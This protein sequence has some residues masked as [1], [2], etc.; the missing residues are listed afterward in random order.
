MRAR[1]R[2]DSR[3]D[4][5]SIARRSRCRASA[6]GA[7]A[8]GAEPR[9][10]RHSTPSCAKLATS[11]PLDA[12]SSYGQPRWVT[13]Y[14]DLPLG[15]VVRF[16]ISKFDRTKCDASSIMVM[17][18]AH[19][20]ATTYTIAIKGCYLSKNIARMYLIA[21]EKGKN[22]DPVLANLDGV[23][24]DYGGLVVANWSPKVCVNLLAWHRSLEAQV[25][26]AVVVANLSYQ[27]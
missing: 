25:W 23:L 12:T 3:E 18:V 10:S 14:V 19:P 1:A 4:R 15:L 11:R 6:A 20:Y 22:I 26:L 21:P 8:A 9:S 7:A 17:V 13:G 5:G 2:E 27:Q 24:E 16:N